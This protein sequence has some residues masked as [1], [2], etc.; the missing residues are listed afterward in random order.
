VKDE[1]TFND[2]TITN[3]SITWFFLFL[4]LPKPFV[5]RS[6]RLGGTKKVKGIVLR[7]AEE[8]IPFF[9]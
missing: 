5:G 7:N 8:T 2:S 6:N 1:Q 3:E 4:R 9:I